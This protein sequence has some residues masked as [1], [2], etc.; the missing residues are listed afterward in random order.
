MVILGINN[1]K[2]K[3]P[4]SKDEIRKLKVGDMVLISGKL[5]TGQDAVH[6]YL[7]DGGKCPVDLNNQIIYHCGPVVLEKNGQY[8]VKAAGQRL[9]LE[10][11]LT[12]GKS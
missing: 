10:K 2:L 6:K 9:Q 1:E 12:S 3:Y 8:E 7:H 5:F 4:F 11:S